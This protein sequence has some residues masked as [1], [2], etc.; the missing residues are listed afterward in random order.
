MDLLLL[1]V[2][3]GIAAILFL[4]WH[5]VDR[6]EN[7]PKIVLICLLLLGFF[8][9][10]VSGKLLAVSGGLLAQKDILAGIFEELLKFLFILPA[11]Y[12]IKEYDDAIDGVVYGV[13]IGIGFGLAE[14]FLYSGNLN[15]YRVLFNGA[16]HSL[17]AGITALVISLIKDKGNTGRVAKMLLTALAPLPA[18]FLHVLT[19]ASFCYAGNSLAA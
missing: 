7:E 3:V 5:N 10:P 17:F 12:F 15:F 9:C 1:A 4:S 14:I 11:I 8:L 16:A 6:Y 19:N 2:S 13:M 18:I